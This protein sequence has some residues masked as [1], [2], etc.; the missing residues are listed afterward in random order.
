MNRYKE[1][2]LQTQQSSSPSKPTAVL[3]ACI[4]SMGAQARPNPGTA[5]QGELLGRTV[6]FKKVA[7]GRLTMLH[8]KATLS[9]MHG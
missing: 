5:Q 2:V 7:S 3:T 1:T 4:S 6:D 9:R 8:C